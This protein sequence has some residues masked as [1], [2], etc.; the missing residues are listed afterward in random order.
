MSFDDNPMTQFIYLMHLRSDLMY[1]K[2]DKLGL[3]NLQPLRDEIEERYNQ[4]IKN[5]P[6]GE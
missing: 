6:T 4:A 2:W 5:K 3:K 1:V